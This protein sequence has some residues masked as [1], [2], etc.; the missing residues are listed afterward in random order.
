MAGLKYR[1][2]KGQDHSL[3]LLRRHT[4]RRG[5]AFEG[6]F[7]SLEELYWEWVAFKDLCDLTMIRRR[8]S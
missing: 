6:A 2:R 8:H 7:Y 4:E 1:T 5:G 3:W